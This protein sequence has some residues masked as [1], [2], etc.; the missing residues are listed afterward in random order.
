M[1]P[2]MEKNL[3]LAM[4]V[5]CRGTAC[6]APVHAWEGGMG[7]NTQGSNPG[8]P[9]FQPGARR[10][11][12]PTGNDTAGFGT[13]PNPDRVPTQGPSG[14]SNPP[15]ERENRFSTLWKSGVPTPSPSKSQPRGGRALSCCRRRA[16]AAMLLRARP[17]SGECR[18]TSCREE[19]ARGRRTAERRTGR[20]AQAV[21]SW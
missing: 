6:C 7:V 4:A 1:A 20:R 3:L 19:V 12:Q 14:G 17:P 18:R 15:G 10:G 16:C 21:S 2:A 9:R 8:L 11:L 13:R 5:L